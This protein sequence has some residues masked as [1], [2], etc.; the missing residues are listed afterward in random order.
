M[1]YEQSQL[2]AEQGKEWE[3]LLDTAVAKFREAKCR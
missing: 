3:A 1:L 2:R